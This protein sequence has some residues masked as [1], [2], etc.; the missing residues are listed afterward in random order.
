MPARG[1]D[2][3]CAGFQGMEMLIAIDALDDL[4]HR[5]PAVPLTDSVRL[6]EDVLRAAVGRVR[7]EATTLFGPEPERDG[8]IS[9]LFGAL[10]GLDELVR[11]AKAVPLTAQVR[12]NKERF[13][14][15][16]DRAREALPEAITERDSEAGSP[17]PWSAVLDEIDALEER[18][19]GFERSLVPWMK[20]DAQ[21]LRDASARVRISA[22]QNL[23]PTNGP[24]DP[25]T[26][27]FAAL[28]ELDALVGDAAPTDRVRVSRL[29][30][31]VLIGRLRQAVA[32]SALPP[33]PLRR[34]DQP[35]ASRTCVP[36]SA[37]SASSGA[38]QGS[39][40][41]A[42]APRLAWIHRSSW[43]TRRRGPSQGRSAA[44][45][46]GDPPGSRPIGPGERPRCRG[47]ARIGGSGL[48]TRGRNFYAFRRARPASAGAP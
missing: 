31:F 41:A 11:T 27:L 32:R 47:A 23:A 21:V 4:I 19:K 24:N 1:S 33:E 30:P 12:M 46:C 9:H 37:G 39:R 28:E 5:A 16:L 18:M 25:I 38:S 40:R 42:A 13:Y 44:H 6:D 15:Q 17:P 35:R 22:R 45:P 2:T 20:V 14:K 3:L 36:A 8:S 7:S 34:P 26:D 29:T 10:D 48:S 43:M